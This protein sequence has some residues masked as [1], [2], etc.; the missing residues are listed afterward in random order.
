[1][2]SGHHRSNEGKGKEELGLANQEC[3]QVTPLQSLKTE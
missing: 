3:Q 1:M 2:H